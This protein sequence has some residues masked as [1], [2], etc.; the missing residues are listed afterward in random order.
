MG[1][2]E[3]VEH[4][5]KKGEENIRHLRDMT[6]AEERKINEE[7]AAKIRQLHEEHEKQIGQIKKE[8]EEKMIPKAEM[9]KKVIILTAEKA[10]SDRLFFL[11]GSSLYKLRDETYLKVFTSLIEE[12]P[13]CKWIEVRVN[14]E[15]ENMAMQSF[16]YSRIIPDESI[17][18]GLKVLG[19]E[20]RLFID[21]TFEKRLERSW[22]NILPLLI[23]DIYH[24]VSKDETHPEL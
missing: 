23:K 18:G 11:A 19:K 20:G 1:Y 6:D 2:Q 15:D 16:P 21:N 3:L 9:G 24:E 10:L 13:Q 8:L 14:P 7:T 22:E 4:L 12:L 5:R 17:T